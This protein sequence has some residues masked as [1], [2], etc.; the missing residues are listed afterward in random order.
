[1]LILALIGIPL[2]GGSV[3]LAL[4]SSGMADRARELLALAIV[5]IS[6][7]LG[8]VV[9]YQVSQATP[10]GEASIAPRIEY[11]PDWMRFKLAAALA[12]NPEGWQ[13]SLGLDGIGATMVLLTLIVAA[14]VL[15]M[16]RKVRSARTVV[17][18]LRG[19]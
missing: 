2:I 16:S 11:S 17:T 5:A 7:V 12:T 18:M 4:R 19:F 1:M 6:L 13:L 9:T 15:V 8:V 14:V 10:I 3:V